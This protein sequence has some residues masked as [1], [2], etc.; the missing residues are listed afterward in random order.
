MHVFD[1][2][3]IFCI[4]RHITILNKILNSAGNYRL[5]EVSDG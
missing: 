1:Y 4:T 5:S 3:I 2:L